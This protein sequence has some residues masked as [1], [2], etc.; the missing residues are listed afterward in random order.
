MTLALVR[1]FLLPA[2]ALAVLG[3]GAALWLA[4]ARE[5]AHVALTAG[6]VATGAPVVWA[7]LRGVLRGVFAADLVAA[8]AIIGSV[9]L[10]EPVAGLVIVV[11]QSGGTALERHAAGRAS[12]AI[13]AL[14]EQSPRTAIIRTPEG[15]R[16]VTADDVRVGDEL[17][18]RPG[19]LV[20][21][22][23][24]VRQ[25]S[26]HVDTSS[27]TG[28]PV[29]RRVVPGAH[30]MSGSRNQ[31]S[32][33]V[34]EAT[35]PAAASQYARIV[36]LVRSAQRSKAPLHRLA[37]RVAVWFTPATLAVVAGTWLVTGDPTRALAVLVVATP[38][39]LLLAT[40]VAIIGGI[41]RAAR[42]GIIIRN[43]TALEHAGQV[44]HAVF[45][46]TGTLTI[47]RP[48]LAD[49]LVMP[50]VDRD[51][52]L[53]T[54]AGL[55]QVS[56]HL[57]ARSLVEAA[58]TLALPMPGSVVEAPG[59]GLEGV[60]EGRRV[61]VGSRS[62]IRERHAD[63]ADA[64]STLDTADDGLH[65]WATVD[66]AAAGAFIFADQPRADMSAALDGLRA[67]GIR[68][69]T[70]LSGD[71]QAAVDVLAAAIGVADARGN[72]LAGEKV[73]AVAALLAEGDKV[74]MTGDGTNDAPALE[75]ATVGVA[76]A[77]HGG[78][79][80]AEAASVILLRDDLRLLP[81][82]VRIG[83]RSLRIARQSIVAGLGLSAAGMVA[84]ALGWLP[85]VAG[86]LFQEAVDVAVIVNALRASRD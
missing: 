25:G 18:V 58:A 10:D 3:L 17:L 35:A 15:L 60:V 14:E 80:T 27:L 22:D 26:S 81:R 36:E 32:P 34:V 84:A 72:L 77:G 57:V 56:S 23:G 1:T 43:G 69:L 11:M 67:L 28:E 79:V 68:R 78:G 76:L 24:I 44:T 48:V 86:A 2:A 53:R 70:L 37:D 55:E 54:V 74:L 73:A 8:L 33:L 6:L 59:R 40:P 16:H 50:G 12:R 62:Y 61:A 20:P 71:Q 42:D 29:P 52:L 66:G 19:D 30:L 39:P 38:C 13:R 41:S 21:A 65:A 83:R 51:G 82:L 4:G 49:L 47:G 63:A 64:L 46:K 9:A 5:T 85:P 75:T 31:E 45:D 7:M